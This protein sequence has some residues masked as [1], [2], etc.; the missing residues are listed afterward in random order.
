MA[1]AGSPPYQPSGAGCGANGS[2]PALLLRP[3]GSSIVARNDQ[4]A[5]WLMLAS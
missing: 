2:K 1:L 3:A 5:G 4:V